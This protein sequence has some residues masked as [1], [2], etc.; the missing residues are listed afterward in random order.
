MKPEK[1]V[2]FATVQSCHALS[3]SVWQRGLRAIFGS[4]EALKSLRIIASGLGFSACRRKMSGRPRKGRV[5]MAKR[6]LVDATH[7][8]ETRVAV[9]DGNRLEDLDYEVASRR[10]LKGN[11]YLAKVIRVE[12]SLQA[13]FV[14]Y[15]GNR[16]GFLAFSEIHP[17]YY[18][19]PVGDRSQMDGDDADLDHD[20]HDDFDAEALNAAILA[21]SVPD[22][23]DHIPALD[24][25][26][27]HHFDAPAAESVDAVI[28]VTGLPAPIAP[29]GEDAP[30]GL[31]RT[32]IEGE[33]AAA[34]SS[35]EGPVLEAPVAAEA[36]EDEEHDEHADA[37]RRARAKLLRQYRIQ[38]VIKR[39]QILLVQ[40][41][42][43]ER[44]NKGAALTTYLSLP[45]RFS[46]L[47]PNSERGGGVSRKITDADD[48]RRLRAILQDL[49]LPEGMGVIL[50]TAGMERSGEDIKR[51]LE[52]LMRLWDSIREL[53]LQSSAPALIYEEANLIKRAIRDLYSDDTVEILVQG[54]AC[55]QAARDLMS[56]LMPDRVDRIKHYENTALPL[57][58]RYQVETQIEALHSH[59]VQL[60]SGGTL[61]INQTEA[62][63]AVDVNSGKSTRE[64]N[65]E[66]TAYR[67]NLEAAEEVARQVR[68]R[69][70]AGLVVIDFIDMED[71][72]N[73]S[74]VERKFKEAMRH[75]RARVQVGRISPF[76]LME[77]SRQ[78]L[79]PSLFETAY[80]KCPHCAGAGYI[81]SLESAALTVLRAVEEEGI[82]QKA[83]E[84]VLHAPTSVA[85]YIL[86]EKR[87]VLATIEARY[88]FRVR[89]QADDELVSPTYNLEKI[90]AK[91]AHERIEMPVIDMNA[92][93]AEPRTQPDSRR[94]SAA[95][96][97][98]EGEA[99]G[100][101][102]PGRRRRRRGGRGG[103]DGAAGA[104]APSQDQG[105]AAGAD[106]GTDADDAGSDA[107]DG[108]GPANGAATGEVGRDGQPR[109]R[110]RG[111]RGGRRRNGGEGQQ[112]A[113]PDATG[114]VPTEG[115]ASTAPA[116]GRQ[117]NN[118]R[119]ANPRPPRAVTQVQDIDTTPKDPRADRG[120]A[121]APATV[122]SAAPA[123]DGSPEA[124]KK[125]WWRRI[126]G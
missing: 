88:G 4:W 87:N 63:V 25:H 60:R 33:D 89:V 53:T 56:M 116:E 105:V 30:T 106:Q 108:D 78:R 121:S 19:I 49:D 94:N 86:N 65:I 13:C 54:E 43:E 118:H 39:R 11:I 27:H 97:D 6:M 123:G 58:F 101:R 67:T 21:E 42:K 8:E 82:R 2:C 110:R 69:D 109:R 95:S 57:F 74:A 22:Y 20:D 102:R 50:R 117:Q 103:A 26:H 73:N 9:I 10:T 68:L 1:R 104:A 90:R 119:H 81:R 80:E 32:V 31:A 99:G 72:R 125:G 120:A 111:R 29:I 107:E 5:I 16:H 92:L 61:V 85:V 79:H 34:P 40:V 66:E 51:D 7:P 47:M 14:E 18:R 96:V 17:D 37:A 77:L 75:D 44:G 83:A 55:Y 46:V 48:R 113:A 38:E 91:A 36:S 62:L 70:L 124:P 35:A 45:G 122:P 98:E 114:A 59:T 126:T 100:D 84:I 3:A 112:G 24:G 93:L 76:G 28:P 71:G 41:V 52:Y 12:P 23:D 15:G 64:R 115:G